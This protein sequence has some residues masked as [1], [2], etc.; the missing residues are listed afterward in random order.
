MIL[1]LTACQ[2]QS[3]PMTPEEQRCEERIYRELQSYC[4]GY[5]RT[6]AYKYAESLELQGHAWADVVYELHQMESTAYKDCMLDRGLQ[7]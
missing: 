3:R 7:P 6:R 4:Q 2:G 5:T 1:S